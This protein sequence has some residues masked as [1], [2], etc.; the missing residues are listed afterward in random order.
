MSSEPLSTP[1]HP[2][3]AAAT[4]SAGKP[5]DTF[6]PSRRGNASAVYIFLCAAAF[7]A[8]LLVINRDLFR[9]PIWEYS[10]Y[11]ANAIQIE[12]AKHFRE[13][14]GNYSRWAFHHPGPGF[15][16]VFALG[17]RLFHDWFRLVPGEMNSH[18][19]TAV[20]VNLAFLFGT[21]AILAKRVK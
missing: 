21:I 4:E 14:L 19:L 7:I 8:T 17:E 11:A 16:Y 9:A 10:D 3:Q 2:I 6:M 5:S 20:L 18:I 1:S 12:R 13:L 15:M